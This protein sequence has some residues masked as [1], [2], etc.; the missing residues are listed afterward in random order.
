M[1]IGTVTIFGANDHMGVN[2][3]AIFAGFG[4]AKVFMV[5]RR[6]ESSI[7]ARARCIAQIRSDS[8]AKNLMPKSYDGAMQ[9][10]FSWIPPL[11]YL[12]L[13]GGKGV[14]GQMIRAAYKGKDLEVAL[15][16][17]SRAPE[18]SKYSFAPF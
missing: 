16:L 18:H 10:G 8:I 11:A 2:V 6:K 7:E 1:K 12:D 4:H 13:F 14:M 15:S 3:A 9:Y 5:S 17:L